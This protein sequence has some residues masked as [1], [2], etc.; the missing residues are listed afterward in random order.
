[1]NG[2]AN[3]V[4]T[5]F[6]SE[7]PKNNPS[8]ELRLANANESI[9][10]EIKKENQDIEENELIIE[11]KQQIETAKRNI[12]K[13]IPHPIHN[14]KKVINLLKETLTETF[15]NSHYMV[16]KIIKKKK[17]ETEDYDDIK[18][19]N[20]YLEELNIYCENIYGKYK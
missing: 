14:D 4:Q 19:Q 18:K 1:M 17:M 20:E 12:E 13:D 9:E 8:M 6:G 15:T 16:Q 10:V 5:Y 2:I 3:Y 11:I 7:T